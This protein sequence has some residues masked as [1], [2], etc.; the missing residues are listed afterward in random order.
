MVEWDT[1]FTYDVF[2]SYSHKDGDWVRDWL[3]PRL[4]DAGLRVCIDF[5]DFDVSVPSL[6]NM[7]RAVANSRKTLVVLSKAWV[8]SR[9]AQLERIL[10]QSIDPLERTIP[11]L[12]EPCEPPPG[13]AM[14]TY[15]DFTQLEMHDDQFQ[16]VIAAI[17]GEL[18]LA[19]IGPRLSKLFAQPGRVPF[20]FKCNPNFVG[21]DTDLAELHR[22]LQNERVVGITGLG[23]I[24]KT[25]VAAEY[26]L[27][28]GDD[29]P[30]GIF[31]LNATS[32]R[33]SELARLGRALSLPEIDP[34]AA[35]ADLRMA[36]AL[37]YYLNDQP[38]ALLV[39]DDLENPAD[40][41]REWIKGIVPVALRCRVLF[42]TRRYAPP[43]FLTHSL[44]V[45]PLDAA[46]KLLLHARPDEQD[47][48]TA[49]TI[50]ATLGYLP[51]AI[52][53]A[54]AYLGQKKKI[55]LAGYLE[56]LTTE[57][58]LTTVDA[59]GLSEADLET[60]HIPSVEATLRLQWELVKDPDA[61]RLFR[62]A[63]LLRETQAIPLA[64]LRLFT[65]LSR[66]AKPGYAS[67]LDNALAALIKVSLVEELTNDQIQLHPLVREFAERLTPGAN[68]RSFT[69]WACRNL[70][71]AYRDPTVLEH[72]ILHRPQGIDDVM[73]DVS[74][75]LTLSSQETAITSFLEEFYRVLDLE[76]HNLRGVQSR[77]M[78]GFVLQQL[79]CR[80][81][82]EKMGYY[83]SAIANQLRSRPDPYLIHRHP[84]AGESPALIRTLRGHT[85]L[86]CACAVTPD[87]KKVVSASPDG[88]RVWELATGREIARIFVGDVKDCAITPDGKRVVSVGGWGPPQV[89]DL[90]TGEELLMLEG[91]TRGQAHSCAITPDGN[92][93]VVTYDKDV[94]LWDLINGIELHT[95]EGE[96][97]LNGHKE[98]VYDC[99]I[100]PD[101]NYAIS[102]SFDR[103]LRLWDLVQKRKDYYHPFYGFHEKMWACAI[104]PDGTKVIA[105]AQD[106]TLKVFDFETGG[107]LMIFEGHTDGVH[108]CIVTPDSKYLISASWDNTLKVW[109]LATG[110]EISTLVGHSFR[111]EDCKVTPPDGK[112]LISA[113]HDSTLKVWDLQRIGEPQPKRSHQCWVTRCIVTPDGKK[114]IS[115]SYDG[116]MK[117]WDIE[118][119][120]ELAVLQGHR[121][122]IMPD[123]RRIVSACADGALRIWDTE[124][125]AEL[126]TLGR[127]G[128]FIGDC[129]VTPDGKSI[130]SWPGNYTMLSDSR[131]Q[132]WDIGTLQERFTWKADRYVVDWCTVTPD[133]TKI[134]LAF[135]TDF[136]HERLSPVMY[137]LDFA[138]ALAGELNILFT[139]PRS[140]T[141]ENCAI[142][143]DGKHLISVSPDNDTSIN[144]WDL[145]TGE[146]VTT[147]SG[148]DDKILRFAASPDGRHFVSVSAYGTLKIWACATWSEVAT[149][150]GHKWGL[151]AC[152]F[153]LD[154]KYVVSGSHDCTL[155]IWSS[156]DGCEISRLESAA[157]FVSIAV[158]PN[159]RDIIAG[160]S[161]GNV[162]FLE[163][164]P[165]RLAEK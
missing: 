100:T 116:T 81:A 163:F 103:S 142:T 2:I 101:G 48:E 120:A 65:R 73:G 97:G 16:R 140:Y 92:I 10:T 151:F 80:I 26:A 23:G 95:F 119:G 76:A 107:V 160:D 3:L 121:C 77:E 132:V 157:D 139:L 86:V 146:L 114:A 152:T 74:E 150:H 38:K 136:V 147:L 155:R 28:H 90:V 84:I 57:G 108:G 14:L 125:G 61:Q 98:W 33:L 156:V 53:L 32:D 75:A 56:R 64:R 39:I 153:T 4:E 47:I 94:K 35:D 1:E 102:V 88:M 12:L 71:D 133:G 24:G 122:A 6:V 40:L 96:R 46:R 148:H 19:E 165:G 111:V 131:L 31:W 66:E 63:G 137:V 13:I 55:S 127:H 117:I 69:R 141:C 41:N 67:P 164:N 87:G 110:R 68:R 109:D 135:W 144:V 18:K 138:D 162:H 89:W 154:G 11:L 123:G 106:G 30:D 21:R 5:R 36:Q 99:A 22:L 159:G 58:G 145:E 83:A 105:G 27:A 51:L 20:P 50:C 130:V 113:S 85:N 54:G 115:A 17:R 134:I 158:A 42:T 79:H 112:Y 70:M 43:G 25:Q 143:P 8:A 161:L 93:L 9:W 128:E 129:V 118:T 78:P 59:V 60:R 37:G 149:L 91:E 34:S 45:L 49:D 62:L 29:Y 82:S 126:S 44:S 104:T 7:E 52:K 15:A 72:H 124:T